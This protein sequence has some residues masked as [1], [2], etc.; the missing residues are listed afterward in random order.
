LLFRLIRIF[1]KQ[2]RAT[3]MTRASALGHKQKF[4]EV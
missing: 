3:D 2:T 4:L 1:A